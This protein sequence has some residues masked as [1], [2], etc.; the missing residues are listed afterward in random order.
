LIPGLKTTKRR[1]E[2]R[3]RFFVALVIKIAIHDFTFC[4]FPTAL[5]KARG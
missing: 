4:G 3:W 5:A 2:N 1:R